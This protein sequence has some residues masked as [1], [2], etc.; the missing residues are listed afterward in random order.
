LE[1]SMLAN[2]EQAIFASNIGL[3]PMNDGETVRINIPPLTEDRRKDLV[4]QV[5]KEGEEAKVSL[6]HARHKLMDFV[7]KAVKDGYPEDSGK[8]KE[9]EVEKMIKQYSDD[10]EELVKSKETEI[11]TV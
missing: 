1:K 11:M 9:A 7:K 8:R 10:I 2:I 3:T 6:R 4:K 5:K